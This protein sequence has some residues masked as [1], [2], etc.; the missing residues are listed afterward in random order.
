MFVGS[1][2]SD[3]LGLRNGER[4]YRISLSNWSFRVLVV[5]PSPLETIVAQAG[6]T[7]ALF[8]EPDV[9]SGEDHP[10]EVERIELRLRGRSARD[11]EDVFRGAAK[12]RVARGL[13]SLEERLLPLFVFV[14]EDGTEGRL[15]D[16]DV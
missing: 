4:R 12:K 7:F 13:T 10:E 8:L 5:E 6:Q 15:E 9:P 3:F 2:W 14:R 1:I 16:L 11:T